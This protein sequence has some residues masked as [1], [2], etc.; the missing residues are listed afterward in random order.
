M[1]D[2]LIIY[3]G[4]IDIIKKPIYGKG[5]KYNDYGLG[6]Y[7]TESLELAKEWAVD[8][9]HS[10]Y[11]NKYE[12]DLKDLKIL[13]LTKEA[14]VLNW[15]TIL[16]QN[17]TF[18]LKNDISKLGKK[19]LIDHFSIN[20]EDYDIIIG[21][22]ADDSYFAYAE[23]FLNNTISLSRLGEALK[24][25]NLGEQIVLKSK[26]AF[27]QIKF[28][29]AFEAEKEIYYPLREKR[30]I[31]ARN[32]FLLNRLGNISIDDLYLNDIIRG[33]DENDSRL[34]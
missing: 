31:K 24:L 25:G 4:S 15:I 20:Y 34:R 30:N 12:L 5:K 18:N 11:A 19:Y 13:N 32:E 6:F 1:N 10:G 14:N 26:K 2:K 27:D 9:D 21:Y 7:S 33:V 17:R 8:I 22:R 3:H 23:S 16:L 29:E 28:I